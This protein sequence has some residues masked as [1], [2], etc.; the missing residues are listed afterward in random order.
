MSYGST[1]KVNP[2]VTNDI[3]GRANKLIDDWNKEKAGKGAKDR[4]DKSING[5]LK[6]ASLVDER[7]KRKDI[8]PL[9]DC[10]YFIQRKPCK[11]VWLLLS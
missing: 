11:K 3:Y 1:P 5:I 6:T 10:I 7:H 8:R 4:N 2:M 9:M